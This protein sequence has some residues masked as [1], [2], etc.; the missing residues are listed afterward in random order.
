MATYAS[1]QTAAKERD[2]LITLTD[3]NLAMSFQY[4]E[5]NIVYHYR[6]QTM[7]N[8]HARQRLSWCFV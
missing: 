8:M 7:I 2:I 4:D 1:C 5:D 3:M 6:G